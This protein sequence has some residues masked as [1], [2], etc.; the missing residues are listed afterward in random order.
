MTQ[1]EMKE[2]LQVAQDMVDSAVFQRNAAQNES[3]QLA[4]QVK[5][6]QR[7]IT[8]LETKLAEKSPVSGEVIPAA[9]K[10]N[11]AEATA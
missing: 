11:G 2:Q 9:P 1:P 10:T 4:A 3:L 7:K 5:A 8:E 6:A